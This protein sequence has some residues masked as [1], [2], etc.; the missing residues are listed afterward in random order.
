MVREP[1]RR[2]SYNEHVSTAREIGERS[3]ARMESLDIAPYPDNYEIWYAFHAGI[4]AELSRKLTDLLEN[5]ESFDSAAFQTIKKSYLGEDASKLLMSTSDSVEATIAG[6][7][8]SISAASNNA[9]DYGVKLE[10]FSGGIEGADS[11]QL[12]ALV[13][14]ALLD[15]KDVM[16]KNAELEEALQ[17]AGQRI[18]NLRDSLD[19]AR[20]AS[21]TDGL[22]GLPNRRAF[23]IG[24]DAEIERAREEDTSLSLLVADV[25]HFKRFNDTYGH[26]VGD[27]VLKLVGRIMK[28]ML[29][30][31]DTP[32]R[33]G[34][35]EFCV[36]LPTTDVKGAFTVAEMLRKAIA[37]KALRSAR[38]GQSFGQVTMSIGASQLHESDTAA[39]MLDRA[40]AALYTAK[41]AGRNKTC[42]ELD[43]ADGASH[44]KAS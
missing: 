34:G 15:T 29:K 37:A 12:K 26:R 13:A 44:R 32:A 31:R 25:D 2:M 38:T 16:A 42:T 1:G 35:E 5:I 14:K 30:G 28:S 33:Y 3:M 10:G 27:E 39:T 24:L 6:A 17:E 40:D 22:T 20:R 23:D 11:E 4:D 7:L 21:E 36:I 8:N 18:E 9:K 19:D 43:L 41:H